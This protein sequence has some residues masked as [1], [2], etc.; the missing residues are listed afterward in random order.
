MLDIPSQGALKQT[1]RNHR[2]LSQSSFA[3]CTQELHSDDKAR[4][5]L[6]GLGR[7]RQRPDRRGL[8]KC[9]PGVAYL[10]RKHP[11]QADAASISSSSATCFGS[12]IKKRF[13]F[14]G[15]KIEPWDKSKALVSPSRL[16]ACF[17]AEWHRP[18]LA[19]VCFSLEL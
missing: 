3:S 15:P 17:S 14:D 8:G 16:D 5:T 9:A 19:V 11:K 7:L 6:A 1:A 2:P 18:A 12:G 10:C 13:C 4:I